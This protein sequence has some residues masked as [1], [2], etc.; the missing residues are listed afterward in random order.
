MKM[1]ALALLIFCGSAYALTFDDY[2]VCRAVSSTVIAEGVTLSF[3]PLNMTDRNGYLNIFAYGTTGGDFL[4]LTIKIY[5]MMGYSNTDTLH[6]ILLKTVVSD[7]TGKTVTLQ[8][9]WRGGHLDPY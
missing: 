2:G 1:L 4:K 6:A 9:S 8:D 7:S 5:G 3:G